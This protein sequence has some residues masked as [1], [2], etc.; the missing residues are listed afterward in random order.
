VPGP[1]RR[2]RA[3]IPADVEFQTK[4]TLGAELVARAAGWKIRR[5]PVLGD[6]AYGNDAKLR[7]RLHDDGIDYVLSVGPE[8]DVFAPETVFAVPPRKPGSRAQP[9]APGPRTAIDRGA[10]WRP[11]RG[12]VAD[13]RV[14]RHRRAPARLAVSRSCA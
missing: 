1:E 12:R 2:K 13:R 5:A 4:L 10:G 9:R 6:Q 3:K 8:C 7:T 14:Q 11:W